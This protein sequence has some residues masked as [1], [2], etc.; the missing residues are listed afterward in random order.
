METTE[1][2]PKTETQVDTVDTK[3]DIEFLARKK[4]APSRFSHHI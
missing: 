4:S 3:P 2:T 1:I